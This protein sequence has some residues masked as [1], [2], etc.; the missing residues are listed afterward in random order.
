MVPIWSTMTCMT[1]ELR[2]EIAKQC[3]AESPAHG[4]G[5]KTA[6]TRSVL[7]FFNIL[8]FEYKFSQTLSDVINILRRRGFSV[9]SRTSSLPKRRCTV[10]MLLRSRKLD[11]GYYLVYVDQHV[12]LVGRDQIIVDTV[13]SRF[14]TVE[15]IYRVEKK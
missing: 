7:R 15:K 6:C 2:Q 4:N 8:A 12:L 10:D 9:R 3:A 13:N 5:F 1:K 14:S 11:H